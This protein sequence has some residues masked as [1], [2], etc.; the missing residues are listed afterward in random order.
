MA[1]PPLPD[2]AVS[3]WIARIAARYDHL[4][5]MLTE[6]LLP[7]DRNAGCLAQCADD[8]A[9]ASL[10][11]ALSLATGQSRSAIAAQRLHGRAIWPREVAAWRPLCVMQDVS[12]SGE[13]Y[14]RRQWG[15][16]Q[17]LVCVQ[18]RCLLVSHCPRC[19]RRAGYRPVSGRQRLWCSHCQDCIETML[20]PHR[21]PFWPF[22]TPQQHGACAAVRLTH[23][24][25]P[26]LLQVQ[27]DLMAVLA[28]GRPG[29]PWARGLKRGRVLEVFRAL[30]F[31][32]L[33]PLWADRHRF[34]P[35]HR[36]SGDTGGLPD[37][38]TP[39]SLPPEVAAP[40]LL[41]SAAL[42]AAE[43]GTPLAGI[44]WNPDLLHAGEREAIC[45]ETLLWHLDAG[46]AALAPRLFTM[47]VTRPMLLLLRALR[48]DCRGLG[49][50]REGVRRR[51]GVRG[52]YRA[53]C[54]KA[55]RELH[56]TEAEREARQRWALL[57]HPPG[58]FTLAH[59]LR[60]NVPPWSPGPMPA[61]LAAWVA[62]LMAAGLDRPDNLLSAWPGCKGTLLEHR[63]V[64]SWLSRHLHMNT[65]VLIS[66]LTAA[67]ET[68]RAQDI[69]LMLPELPVLPAA[70]YRTP[71]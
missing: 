6:H 10:D 7:G 2:E 61:D 34:L 69:G 18:H 43:G 8:G 50:G 9:I 22:G 30:S 29:G 48:A 45:T 51:Q 35:E 19:L 65:D 59:V 52:A 56:E 67:V 42:L 1:P 58:Y 26:T 13:S 46:D 55:R 66:T 36:M 70:S 57:K 4:P 41:A 32:M 44:G 54:C 31:V 33:G 53:E 3:S 71:W 49:A 60:K 39:G 68:S 24:A 14:A 16:G 21:I 38:W 15:A 23:D 64:R 5:E 63:Y 28:G 27:S 62:V 40:A 25:V 11:A 12:A 37:E 20:K 47:P 17:Y